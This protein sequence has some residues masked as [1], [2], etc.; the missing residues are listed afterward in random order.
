M[1]DMAAWFTILVMAIVM[2]IGFAFGYWLGRYEERE[3]WDGIERKKFIDRK[4]K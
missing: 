3:M 2:A 1:S 4:D